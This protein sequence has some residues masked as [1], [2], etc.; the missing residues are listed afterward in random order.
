MSSAISEYPLVSILMTVYNREKFISD[1]IES[2][3]Q[4]TYSNWELIITDDCSTDNSLA[5]A[6]RYMEKDDRI[7]VY[8]NEINL[9]DY[10]NRNQAASYARGK[11]IK[12]LDSDDLIYPHGLGVMVNAMERFTEAAFALSYSM[13]EDVKPYP[14][15]LTPGETFRTHFLGRGVL[16]CGPSGTIIKRDVFEKEEGF[17]V[18]RFLGDTELWLR[19]ASKYPVVKMQ[20]ALIWWRQHDG[21]EI[22][23]GNTSDYYTVETFQLYKNTLESNSC[24]LNEAERQMALRKLKQ[25][26]ARKIL[27]LGIMSRQLRRAYHIYRKTDINFLQ[28]LGGFKTGQQVSYK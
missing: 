9:G 26:Q 13:P 11:Y 1:A 18:K 6:K 2:V 24:P 5:I 4:L 28:L 19:L 20:P 14:F 21:Q 22:K 25:Q 12:Y 23:V 27:K 17:K 8:K 10:P 3:L 16:N 15:V 7:K